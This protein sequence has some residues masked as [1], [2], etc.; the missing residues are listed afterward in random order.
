[1]KKNIKYLLII[2]VAI[3]LFSCS[4]EKQITVRVSNST[5]K[6]LKDAFIS[7]PLNTKGKFYL[8]KDGS[9]EV[10]SQIIRS[11]G[12]DELIFVTDLTPKEVKIFQIDKISESD[13]K[14]FK[15]RT[16][17][18]L[19]PKEGS[20]YFDKRFRGSKFTKVSKYKVPK[21]HTDHDALFK[22]EGPGWE[23]EKVGYRFYLDW[24]NA[25]DIFGKKFDKL[26]LDQVGTHDTVAQDDSYHS[27]L[28]WGMDVF[29]V[30]NSLG[31]GSVGMWADDKVNMVSKTDSVICEIPYTG[32]IEARI[33]THYYGWQVGNEKYNLDASLVINAGS[34]LT[35]CILEISDN[36]NN[37]V[38]GIAKHEN[39]ELIKSN[40][41]NGWNYLALYGRQSLSGDED[42]LGIVIFY[43][44][45]Y[46]EKLF[47]DDLSYI[48]KLKPENGRVNYYF[49]AAWDKEENGI[50]NIDEFE[51]Y[52][53]NTIKELNNPPAVKLN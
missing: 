35:N 27:M 48:I 22:Y 6:A 7:V 43:N 42:K 47:E 33:N 38:S 16:Y 17:A 13:V 36:A 24:R 23:S 3:S 14:S 10:P 9:S 25:T 29:K 21:I 41:K 51:N 15:L 39:A 28:D 50:K 5:D 11:D 32:P 34:R 44:T 2:T 8:L 45:K 20:V 18:E 4:S 19:S 1:M 52:L 30:G 37:I 46:L 53:V 49:A 40:Y 12:E 31:I 26:I